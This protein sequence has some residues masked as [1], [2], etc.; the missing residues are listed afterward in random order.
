TDARNAIAERRQLEKRLAESQRVEG[1]GLLAGGIAHDFN[2]LLV[3]VMGNADLALLAVEPEASA[4]K[5]LGRIRTAAQRL[6]DLAHQ[7]LTY[8]GRKPT[9]VKAVDLGAVIREMLELIASSIP[10]NVQVDLTLPEGLPPVAGDS[11]QLG[12]VIVNLV[13][14]AAEAIGALP[15]A[16]R[17]AARR[18][19]LDS[20]RTA[21]LTLRSVRG[22]LDHVCLEV[23]DDGPG[24]DE[25]TRA[26]IFDPFFTTKG[27]RGR[28]LGLASVI[29]IVR[30]HQ[31][32]LQVDSARG[33]GARVR[34]WLPLAEE[35]VR[36][37]PVKPGLPSS[38]PP[39]TGRVLIVDDE[40]VVRE[41]I[42]AILEMQGFTVLAAADGECAVEAVHNAGGIDV[43]V[44]DLTIPGS[45]AEDTHRALRQLL[46]HAGIL[47]TSG[48]S[49]PGTLD[50]L[51]EDRRTRFI[52]K[53]FSAESLSQHIVGLLR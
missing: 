19:F 11:A 47:L 44:L 3:G 45:S 40:P 15:G 25:A 32:A 2:N 12:Q 34:V 14:N 23:W 21:S 43:V 37:Q 38:L 46:P 30:A 52:Q 29:G 39:R 22:A 35:L 50:K 53:P 9:S 31:G 17:V 42:A 16:I 5:F 26:R 28:G 4:H 36:A 10:P 24:M 27:A 7:M 51:C 6:A 48:Y 41:T 49:E 20:A 8:S 1:L 33:E 13:M 18:E